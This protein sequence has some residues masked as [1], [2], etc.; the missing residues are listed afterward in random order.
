MARNSPESAGDEDAS[1]SSEE[2]EE[3]GRFHA[4]PLDVLV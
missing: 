1:S 4:P 3:E 2:E